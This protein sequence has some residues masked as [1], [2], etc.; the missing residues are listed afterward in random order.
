VSRVIRT[1]SLHHAAKVLQIPV[2]LLKS[3]V[4]AGVVSQRLTFTTLSLL[5]GAR[6]AILT[7]EGELFPIPAIDA[8]PGSRLDLAPRLSA[9]AAARV[10]CQTAMGLVRQGR[11]G[12]AA[13]KFH[14]AIDMDP[15]YAEPFRELGHLR[16]SEGRMAEAEA[17]FERAEALVPVVARMPVE[18]VRGGSRASR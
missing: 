9:R 3:L 2:F 10:L 11:P 6:K 15:R 17:F 18:T 16:L 5:R 1:F 8:A 14:E 4:E 7:G 13:T 12:E